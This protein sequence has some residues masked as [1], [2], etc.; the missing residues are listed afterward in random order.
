MNGLAAGPAVR[1]LTVAD[2]DRRECLALEPESCL[3]SRRVKRVPGWIITQRGRAEALR[4]ENG[5]EFTSRDFLAWRE[6]RPMQN[7]LVESFNGRLPDECWN[8]NWLQTLAAAQ[9]KIEGWREEYSQE[10]PH[11][12]L[13]C[14]R[15]AEFGRGQPPSPP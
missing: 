7:G 12:S 1:V 9:R 6:E 3:S 10:R 13:G 8:A 14:L 5:P 2:E 15:P 11:G 4:C